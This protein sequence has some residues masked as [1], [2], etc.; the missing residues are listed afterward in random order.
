MDASLEREGQLKGRCHKRINS[1]RESL[2]LVNNRYQGVEVSR[3]FTPAAMGF[4][5][6]LLEP[7]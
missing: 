3:N 2:I 6:P 7:M 4:G 5:V 1:W